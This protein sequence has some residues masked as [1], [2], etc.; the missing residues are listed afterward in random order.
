MAAGSRG[1]SDPIGDLQ[2]HLVVYS[3]A[4]ADS[5]YAIEHAR[6]L[7]AADFATW[8]GSLRS[9]VLEL[10]RLAA[11]IPDYSA[12]V[13]P[14]ETLSARVAAGEARLVALVEGLSASIAS[15]ERK[16]ESSTAV[17]QGALAAAVAT[18][19]DTHAAGGGMQE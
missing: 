14:R 11:A 7:S 13:G 17:L 10:D 15:A 2:R 18:G 3:K 5:L 4:L 6:T 8:H 1:S 19:T 9:A 16:L 12:L